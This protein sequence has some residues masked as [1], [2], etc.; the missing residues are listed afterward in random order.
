MNMIAHREFL[1]EPDILAFQRRATA[2]LRSEQ[3]LG[4]MFDD[5]VVE[6]IV[7][8]LHALTPPYAV[9]VSTTWDRFQ[10]TMVLRVDTDT[11]HV[12]VVA[13]DALYT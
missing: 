11:T 9:I 4:T 13:S 10:I 5:T 1:P 2:R 7:N 6:Q 8:R 12:V 3:L